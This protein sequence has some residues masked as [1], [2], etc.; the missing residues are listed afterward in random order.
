MS[1]RDLLL[2]QF[3]HVSCACV[4][5]GDRN[6]DT[7]YELATH[8]PNW[9]LARLE[10]NDWLQVRDAMLQQTKDEDIEFGTRGKWITDDLQVWKNVSIPLDDSDDPFWIMLVTKCVHVFQE[11]LLDGWNNQYQT[12]DVIICGYWY[13]RLQ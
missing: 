6:S 8:V 9:T 1:T 11:S 13:E 10:P 5:R 3:R 7:K 12:W 2:I 4:S